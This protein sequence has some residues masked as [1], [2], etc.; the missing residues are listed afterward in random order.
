MESDRRLRKRDRTRRALLKSALSLFAERGIYEPSIEDVTARADV[1]KGTFYQYFASR[2]ALIAELVR[3]GFALLSA[4]M[5]ALEGSESR[6]TPSEI[7]ALEAHETFFR[8]RPEYLLLFHQARGWM[9]M[10]RTH[11]RALREAFEVYVSD[12]ARRLSNSVG[13]PDAAARRE[14]TA[15][16]GFIAGVL[17]FRKIL[18]E[19]S[20]ERALVKDL[21]LLSRICA[22]RPGARKTLPAQDR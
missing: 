9:K 22:A 11:G 10:S 7:R 5:D 15:L 14:A 13:D 21:G 8:N 16:A 19:D 2:E 17:S 6:D 12:L 4:E 18:G 3:E 1:G 20:E